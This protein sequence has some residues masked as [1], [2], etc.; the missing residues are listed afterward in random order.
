LKRLPGAVCFL[1][2]V[3]L[4]DSLREPE[5]EYEVLKTTRRIFYGGA[6]L[7]KIAG[8]QL[9]E[10]GVPLIQVYGT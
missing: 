10:M 5:E 9:I 1:A 8:K 7:N 6:P 4:E 2:P 3:L